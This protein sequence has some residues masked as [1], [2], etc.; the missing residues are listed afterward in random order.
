VGTIRVRISSEAATVIALTPVVV[1][2]MSLSEL[3]AMI[4]AVTGKDRVRIAE[5]LKV[6]SFLSGTSRLRWSPFTATES[7]L[8]SALN[9]L[10]D[11]DPE[12]PFRMDR[13]TKVVLR[14][15]GSS[16]AITRESGARRR[17][18]RRSS[19]WDR[20]PEILL[21]PQYVTYAYADHA[22]MYRCDVNSEQHA[23][24]QEAAGLLPDRTLANRIR[25][26]AIDGA[27]LYCAL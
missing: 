16:L 5:V 13:C 18:F 4:V 19:F 10:P 27:D 3:A 7:E 8:A 12:R 21:N 26:A 22:D 25:A 6:G 14:S 15:R 1:Q 9:R 20:L 17:L 24:L 11:P 23:V 2:E